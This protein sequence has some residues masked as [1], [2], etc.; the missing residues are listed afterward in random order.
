M[1]RKA[2]EELDLYNFEEKNTAKKKKNKK[3]KTAKKVSKTN[4]KKKSS[5][6][7]ENDLFSIDE[8]M[9]IGITKKQKE[10]VENREKNNKKQSKVVNK[11]KVSKNKK[12]KRS[13]NIKNKLTQEEIEIKQRKR[14]T[15]LK[16]LK[17]LMII[18]LFITL[19]II[20]MFSPIFNIKNI[21]VTGNEKITENEII[22]LSG[23]QLEEN[24]YKITKYKV[25]QKIK[26]NAYIE[27]VKI[28]RKLPSEIQ[29]SVTE[30][31]PAFII[32]YGA[33]FVYIDNQGYILEIST[34]KLELPILQGL[35]TES[36]NFI[37]GNRLENNDL[38]KMN[39]VLKIMEIAKNNEIANLI[40]RI[41]VED[42]SNYKI[43]LETKE[44]TA[45]LGDDSNLNTKILTIKAILEKTEGTAGEIF[46]NMDLNNN[47]PIFRQRV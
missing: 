14:R 7:T 4:N 46:V 37:E 1:A 38:Q 9:I 15:T 28:K 3:S 33:S 31:K 30:R 32:E 12:K 16:V 17:Y 5:N 20:A 45:Y 22:S 13:N 23:I 41:D 27:D 44:K 6:K 39:T 11:K 26:E 19:I 29:I 43:L 35:Q 2:K 24:T 8:E 42:E 18:A 25:K 21:T 10:P 40:T 47:Y 36:A 34:E